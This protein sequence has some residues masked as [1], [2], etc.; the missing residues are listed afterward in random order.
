[1]AQW[2]H[3][4]IF[5]VEVGCT[6]S[7]RATSGLVDISGICECL[8]SVPTVPIGFTLATKLQSAKADQDNILL[9]GLIKL[10]RGD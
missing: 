2:G 5:G 10:K 3:C 8:G 6:E 4:M 7:H 1:M 9:S